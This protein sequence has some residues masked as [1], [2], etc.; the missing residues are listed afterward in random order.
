[1]IDSLS[2]QEE[3]HGIL[4][5]Q[6]CFRGAIA[7]CALISCWMSRFYMGDDGVSYLDMG[8]LYWK[9]DWHAALNGLWSPLYGWLT[10]LMFL[11]TKPTMRWEYSEVELM[12]FAIFIGALFCFEFFWRQL[13]AFRGGKAWAGG[14]RTFAWVLGYLL[15]AY[16]HLV[17]HPLVLVTPDL[18]VAALLYVASGMM[19]RFA[20]GRMGA[21]SA[22]LLGVTLG[23][24]YLAKAAM[25]PFAVV[26]LMA[27]LVVAWKQHRGKSL[28]AFTLLGFL[29]T[30]LPFIAALSWNMHRLTWGDS[31]KL[32]YGWWVNYYPDPPARFWQGDR[33][34]HE[35]ALHPPR[36]VFGWPEVYEFAA[37][38]EGTYPVWYDPCYWNAGIDSRIHPLR[39]AQV[40]AH[41]MKEMTRG[42]L[43]K[44]PLVATLVLLLLVSERVPLRKGIKDWWRN[45]MTFWP[46]LIPAV[47]VCLMYMMVHW[48]P[49]FTSG[50]MLIAWG[51]AIVATGISGAERSTKLFWA[52]SLLLSAWVVYRF[53]TLLV[54]YHH[55]EERTSARAVMVAEG[56]RAMGIEPGDHVALIGEGFVEEY[57]AR[58]EKVRIIAEVP[59][60]GHK[61]LANSAA[62]FWKS[63]PE[64][65]NAVLDI[66]KSTGAKAVIA[67]TPPTNLPLRWVPVG[68]TG[69][70][71]YFFR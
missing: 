59:R 43:L 25:L 46:I 18:L 52:V 41:N 4:R 45:L 69:H 3:Q 61:E 11:L 26:F 60:S 57:W 39:Q 65:E 58:L 16:V 17:I 33:P 10:G 40:F 27:M 67:D 51:A 28:Y 2:R 38:I 5:V 37:P 9:G 62:A 15:F 56:L 31:A 23:V 42:I 1:M 34:G 30:S 44:S 8:D 19:L 22:I 21:T 32:N 24:G 12:N 48:E 70:A 63:S 71:I 36:K 50:E 20:S 55:I 13:L 14:A 29:I 53:S 68:N 6:W 54:I 47:A 66:L 64:G 35:D 49:R 7:V